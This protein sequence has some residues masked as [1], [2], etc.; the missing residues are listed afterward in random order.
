MRITNWGLFLL[1][2]YLILNGLTYFDVL[3]GLGQVTPLLGIVSGVL[4]V[5]EHWRR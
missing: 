5:M 4:I 3:R 1:G 2:V